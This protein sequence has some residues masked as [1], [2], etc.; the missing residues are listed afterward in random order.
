MLGEGERR[1]GGKERRKTYRCT[2]VEC[3][4]NDGGHAV[5]NV[6][7]REEGECLPVLPVSVK[8]RRDLS[9]S[10]Q[11]GWRVIVNTMV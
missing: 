7:A 9:F 10:K 6:G 1:K 8:I 11:K 2:N 4:A 3:L 5:G